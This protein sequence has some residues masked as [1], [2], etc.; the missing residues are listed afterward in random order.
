[1]SCGW[2]VTSR[3]ID[4]DT[5]LSPRGSA[6]PLAA[7]S[8]HPVVMVS[9]VL[10]EKKIWLWLRLHQAS[11]HL[12]E[13]YYPAGRVGKLSIDGRDTSCGLRLHASVGKQRICA[14][15]TRPRSGQTSV[16]RKHMSFERN[17]RFHA[18]VLL[19]IIVSV[20]VS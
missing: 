18:I 14:S 10:E 5:R 2:R 12:L 16:G 20:C 1:M 3:A 6:P 4:C 8:P 9:A 7:F 15:L 17:I 11:A 19:L 13:C